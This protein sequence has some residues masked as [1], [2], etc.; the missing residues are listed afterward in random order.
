MKQEDFFPHENDLEEIVLKLYGLFY[1]QTQQTIRGLFCFQKYFECIVTL[2]LLFVCLYMP[3]VNVALFNHL[4]NL[5]QRN[6]KIIVKI[7]KLAY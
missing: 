1:M 6:D 7:R 3:F 4:V 5:I 2:S